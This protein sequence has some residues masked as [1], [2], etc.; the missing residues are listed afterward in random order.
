MNL[1]LDVLNVIL[2]EIT[3]YVIE[4]QLKVFVIFLVDLSSKNM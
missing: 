4:N 2:L 3:F 1:F